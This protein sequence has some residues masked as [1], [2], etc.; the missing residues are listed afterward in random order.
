MTTT[1][2]PR[3]RPKN[4]SKSARKQDIDRLK[5][6][7]R[8]ILLNMN[9]ELENKKPPAFASVEGWE[10]AHALVFGKAPLSDSLV[11]LSD[12]LLKLNDVDVEE[13]SGDGA[14]LAQTDVALVEAFLRKIGEHYEAA[15]PK[16]PEAE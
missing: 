5:G 3:G 1:K 14:P 2:R 12:L 7:T 9:K 4:T 10:K 13:K 16:K 6:L 15:A 8:K 11:T